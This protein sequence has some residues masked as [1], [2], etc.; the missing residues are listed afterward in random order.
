M[1]DRVHKV[2]VAMNIGY[3]TDSGG[4]I[5][6]GFPYL[7]EVV[8]FKQFKETI[9]DSYYVIMEMAHERFVSL[10]SVQLYLVI[11]QD[12]DEENYLE[13]E[14]KINMMNLKGYKEKLDHIKELSYGEKCTFFKK[15]KR[16]QKIEEIF[17]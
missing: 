3:E 17:G 7:T 8:D 2:R 13:W 11:A 5:L 15:L 1:K 4:G 9:Y 12:I 6:N 16:K 10:K 14:Y